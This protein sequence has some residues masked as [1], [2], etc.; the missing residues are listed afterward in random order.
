MKKR[1]LEI[2]GRSNEMRVWRN[3]PIREGKK[4]CFK[5]AFFV[6]KC[7]GMGKRVIVTDL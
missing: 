1:Y 3:E 6:L 7:F 4:G 2:E 5:N